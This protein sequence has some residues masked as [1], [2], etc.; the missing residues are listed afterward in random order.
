MVTF[1][2]MSSV[3][4]SYPFQAGHL[5][6]AIRSL[7]ISSALLVIILLMPGCK[8]HPSHQA[9]PGNTIPVED[10]LGRKTKVPAKIES[11]VGIGPG[12][13]R[14]LVY[15]QVTDRVAGVE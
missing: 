3:R 9:D 12:A 7:M 15:M 5:R 14:L 11:I 13:L 8:G 10:M 6:K 2:S 4:K 1:Q